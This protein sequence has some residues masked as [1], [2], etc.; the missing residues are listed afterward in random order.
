M[1]Y[2]YAVPDQNA[3]RFT[4]FTGEREP[5]PRE[6]FEDG[7]YAMTDSL[8]RWV[9]QEKNECHIMDLFCERNAAFQRDEIIERWDGE[10]REGKWS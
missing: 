2:A 3:V 1:G 6:L 9:R 8:M 5:T 4:Q 10:V 7:D